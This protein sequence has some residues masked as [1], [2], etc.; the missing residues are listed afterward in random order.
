MHHGANVEFFR[1]RCTV[2]TCR[3]PGERAEGRAFVERERER[4]E[5]R[6]TSSEWRPERF[7]PH[8]YREI[9]RVFLLTATVVMYIRHPAVELLVARAPF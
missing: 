2:H 6:T 3:R 4:S 7:R 5:F 1:I 9:Y 8:L